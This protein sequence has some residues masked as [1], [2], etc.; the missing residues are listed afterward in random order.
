VSDTVERACIS[1]VVW[2]MVS[3]NSL[4]LFI[5]G[6]SFSH[7]AGFLLKLMI[8]YFKIILS[9]CLSL[10]LCLSFSVYLC[11]SISVSDYLSLSVCL[12]VFLS[13]CLSFSH[14]HTHTAESVYYCF[15]VHIFRADHFRI[16]KLPRSLSLEK[17]EYPS[18]RSR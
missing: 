15:C 6:H 1:S 14:T 11:V 5:I 13:L 8:S 3:Q 2:S 12:S 16:N 18:L 4:S 9:V 7:T 17:T 10:P